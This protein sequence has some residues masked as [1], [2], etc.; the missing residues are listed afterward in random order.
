MPNTDTAEAA[1]LAWV[2]DAESDQRIPVTIEDATIKYYGSST[3]KHVRRLSCLCINGAGDYEEP[4]RFWLPM[5]AL[6]E[7]ESRGVRA[8]DEHDVTQGALERYIAA[9]A[10]YAE[11]GQPELHW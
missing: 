9:Q 1:A 10:L 11:F 3:N 2:H 8:S 6:E 7:L 5:S 4:R